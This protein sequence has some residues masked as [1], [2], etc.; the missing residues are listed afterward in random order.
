MQNK[1]VASIFR[2]IADILEIKDENVFRIR[3]YRAAASNIEGLPRQLSE[4]YGEDPVLISGIP[5]IGKDLS[6]KIKEMVITGHLEFFSRLMGEFPPGF[7][8]LLGISG[9][10]PK[11]LKKL[12]DTL[13]IENVDDLEKSCRANKVSGL[14]G[15]GVK[16][17]QKMLDAIARFRRNEGR[18]T[19]DKAGELADEVIAYLS[20]DP[21]FKKIEKAGSLRRGVETVGDIDLL[22]VVKDTASAAERFVSFSGRE[23]ITAKGST[24]CSIK[25]G[26]ACQIDLRMVD[27]DCFGAALVYFT[28]SKQHNIKIRHLA[29]KQKRKVSEYGVFSVSPSGREKF[30]AGEKEK[31]VYGKLGMRWIPPELREDRGEIEAALTGKLPRS[32]VALGD[33]RG[34]LHLHTVDTDGKMSIEDLIECA[35][36]KGYEYMAVTNHS[37]L[38]RIA[39]GMDE[40][41]LLKHIENIRKTARKYRNIAVLA[42][43]EVDILKDGTLDMEDYVLKELDIVIAAVHSNF[44]ADKESQTRRLI[45]AMDNK[46]VN[47][48]AHPSGRLITKRDP[49][50]FDT[51][52]VFAAAAENNVILEINTHGERVDLNDVNCI[53]AKELGARFSINTDSHEAHQMDGMALGV[54]TARRAWL[55]K[56]E[57]VNTYTFDKLK[58]TLKR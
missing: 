37:K 38:V 33:V 52:K 43:V 55:E 57:V 16:T 32:L 31:D 25:I 53:R 17:Q 36:K 7:L 40:K 14:E 34:D 58:K 48:L 8:D 54:A 3:A 1:E 42:G 12:K 20:E 22:A 26:G 19:A 28:G 24:K 35:I 41:R 29:K 50:D 27:A 39:N 5:G 10:G 2:D 9:L 49:L 13:G 45:R 4:I 18:M 21:N 44:L 51:D 46:Y 30:I 56:K 47:M 15:L 6:E 11:K 23:E